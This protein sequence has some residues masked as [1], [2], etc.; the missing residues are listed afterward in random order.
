MLHWSL[1][2]QTVVLRRRGPSASRK[3]PYS[4]RRSKT[5]SPDA[6]LDP[7]GEYLQ[8]TPCRQRSAAVRASERAFAPPL[9]ET[10]SGPRMPVRSP[11]ARP[12]ILC[13][14]HRS[15]P[16]SSGRPA[17]AVRARASP[18]AWLRSSRRS[19]RDSCPSAPR[20]ADPT[21]H[22]G[23][24]SSAPRPTPPPSSVTKR[25]APPG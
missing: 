15:R 22:T 18:V 4:V 6:T 14:R 3:Q 17:A 12:K 2:Q 19:C 13:P 5:G 21:L 7:D 24:P 10:Q 16:R 25:T 1:T 20:A 9:S 11:L 8:Q 23:P